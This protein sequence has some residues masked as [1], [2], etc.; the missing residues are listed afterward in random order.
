VGS[1]EEQHGTEPD[2]ALGVPARLELDELLE[3]LIGR[4]QE[5]LG[6][7]GRLRGLL[8]ATQEVAVGVDLEQ[9]LRHIVGAGREL[10]GARY[11]AL[12]VV[13]HG[14]LTQFIHEGID[15]E[16]VRRIGHLPAGKGILGRLVDDPRTL[17]LRRLDEHPASTG[18][19]AEHPPMSSLLGVPIRVR[20]RVFGNLYLTEK[21][22]AEEFTADD[23]ALI[24]ALAAAAGV[25]IENAMLFTETRHRQAWQSASTAFTTALL[26]GEEPSKILQRIVRIAKQLGNAEGAAL[27][28]PTDDPAS[29]LVAATD[30]ELLA[31]FEH[32]RFPVEG[33]L[34][35]LTLAAGRTV[36]VDDLADDPR[37]GSS[38][39]AGAVGPAIA[40]PLGRDGLP[41]GVLAVYR[42]REA[43]TVSPAEVEMISAFALHAGLALE[44][45][46]ARLDQETGRLA[47]ERERIAEQLNADVM[48][49][50]LSISTGLY[51][52]LPRIPDPALLRAVR[53]YAD[54]IDRAARRI[55]TSVFDIDRPLHDGEPAATGPSR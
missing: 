17:R 4:A 3:Q 27:L 48:S 35:G 42:R 2:P 44:L 43:E 22:G 41:R 1:A 55:G 15:E 10:V 36:V 8:R 11:A 53:E 49:E 25:A 39:V 51:G 20:D 33:S 18:F 37:L 28:L 26:G 6:T 16:T 5:V 13:S 29:L 7:Q 52:V 32:T 9:V 50:L 46:R 45:A 34:S 14:Q 54:R 31:E 47:A 23:E 38:P 12:G 24:L 19:P 40:A 30:G 21:Q